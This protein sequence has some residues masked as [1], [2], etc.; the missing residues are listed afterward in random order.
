MTG[1]V[2]THLLTYAVS[3]VD[4]NSYIRKKKKGHNEQCTIF[5]NTSSSIST[6]DGSIKPLCGC[7]D[8]TKNVGKRTTCQRSICWM[9]MRL[10]INNDFLILSVHIVDS[11]TMSHVLVSVDNSPFDSLIWCIKFQCHDTLFK[12]ILKSSDVITF[13]ENTSMNCR[14]STKT[15]ELNKTLKLCCLWTKFER[16]QK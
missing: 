8:D 6:R 7:D 13:I 10:R 2:R 1:L 12:S 9:T 15:L 3:I 11:P 14:I 5:N 4:K 16:L